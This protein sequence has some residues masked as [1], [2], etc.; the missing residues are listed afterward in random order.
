MKT[1]ETSE[2]IAEK[3]RGLHVTITHIS[4]DSCLRVPNWI[5]Q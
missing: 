2:Q 3:S 4:F 5:S 1:L